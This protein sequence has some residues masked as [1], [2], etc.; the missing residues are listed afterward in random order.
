MPKWE[1]KVIQLIGNPEEH[2]K[3]LNQLADEGW[4]LVSLA[5]EY[6]F[7]YLKREKHSER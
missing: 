7:A 5:M 6:P 4:E 3:Q 2:Q 1:Y